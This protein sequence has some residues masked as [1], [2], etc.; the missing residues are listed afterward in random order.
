[1][2]YSYY[3]GLLLGFH[4]CNKDTYDRVI[5][6]S[7]Q[8]SKSE[9]R[10]DWLGHGIYFWENSYARALDWAKEKCRKTGDAAAVVGA[11]LDLG[12]C[13]NLTDYQNSEFVKKGYFALKEHMKAKGKPL[14]KNQKGRNGDD[15]LFRDLDCAV[16]NY[17]NDLLENEKEREKEHEKKHSSFDS[18]RGIFTEGVPIYSGAGFREKTHV[19]ICIRKPV[20]I[21]GY[22][23]GRT[24]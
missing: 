22:F 8:L 11:A 10:Y 21:K 12:Y 13:L 7:G 4:G 15:W 3:P 1:M 17:I 23:A 14:P 20:C 5:R 2:I 9:N 6:N 16:I 24:T 19:Q 18:V